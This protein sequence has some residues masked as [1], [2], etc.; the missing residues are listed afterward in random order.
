MIQEDCQTDQRDVQAV[1]RQQGISESQFDYLKSRYGGL[2]IE[3]ALRLDAK[4]DPLKRKIEGIL[5]RY[6]GKNRGQKVKAELDVLRRKLLGLA[7]WRG[8]VGLV[9]RPILILLGPRVFWHFQE[10]LWRIESRQTIWQLSPQDEASG[11]EVVATLKKDGLAF[12]RGFCSEQFLLEANASISPL[13]QKAKERLS[14]LPDGVGDIFDHAT[15]HRFIRDAPLDYAGR[16]RV[17]LEGWPHDGEK[18]IPDWVRSLVDDPRLLQVAKNYFGVPVSIKRFSVDELL[19]SRI[20]LEWH[21]DTVHDTLKAFI[22][23]DDV[24]LDNGPTQ[25]KV[26]SHRA[27]G[28]STRRTYYLMHKY[29]SPY[30]YPG[31]IQCSA[32]GEIIFGTGRAGDC[33]F[34]DPK[35]LHAAIHCKEGKRVVF[36]VTFQINSSRNKML[37]ATGTL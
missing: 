3:E 26:G 29:G 25:Y 5:F 12:W 17:R 4:R 30:H 28:A 8:W 33:M 24:A 37:T 35:G 10:M 16:T 23:L 11:K 21:S 31:P 13:V 20:N 2:A 18:E 7:S 34:F 1:C 14:E 9:L 32:P 27:G 15:G 19:P 6:L 36:I 22:L